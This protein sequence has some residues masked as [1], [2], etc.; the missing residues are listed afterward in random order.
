MGRLAGSTG[1]SRYCFGSSG[2]AELWVSSTF[3]GRLARSAQPFGRSGL[4]ALLIL[5]LQSEASYDHYR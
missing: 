3:N 4:V 2:E 1:A 5:G